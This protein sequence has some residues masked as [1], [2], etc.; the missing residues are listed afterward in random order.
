MAMN[1]CVD[2]RNIQTEVS[3]DRRSYK[4]ARAERQNPVDGKLSF[5]YC[6]TMRLHG[7]PCGPD[8]ALFEANG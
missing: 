4:C 7:Q 2:C 1:I 3:Q 6:E 5:F 8:G